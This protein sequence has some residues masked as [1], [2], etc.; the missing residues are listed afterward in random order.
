[1]RQ[2]KTKTPHGTEITVT[3][4]ADKSLGLEWLRVVGTLPSGGEFLNVKMSYNAAWAMMMALHTFLPEQGA[5]CT[6]EIVSDV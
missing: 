3:Q 1:M 4:T 5:D 2:V 6:T